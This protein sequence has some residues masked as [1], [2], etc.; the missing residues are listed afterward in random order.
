M[1]GIT[2]NLGALN[3]VYEMELKDSNTHLKAMNKFYTNVSAV[4][5]NI[6][7]AGKSSAQ[8]REELGKLTGNLSSLNKVYG[9]MLTVM[10]R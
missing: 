8:F 9:D 7:E 5:E 6:A 2:K 10:K 4:M 3:S 1:Q